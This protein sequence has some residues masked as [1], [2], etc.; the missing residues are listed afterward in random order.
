MA[1]TALSEALARI[2]QAESP[3]E[4]L[5]NAK[6]AAL[7]AAYHQ[8]WQEQNATLFPVEVEKTVELP[9]LNPATGRKSK[10]FRWAGKRDAI[11]RDAQNQLWLVE[12]KT[13]SDNIE[14]GSPYWKRLRIDSQISAYAL[15]CLQEGL[16]VAGV[17]YDVIRKPEIEP[18]KVKPEKDAVLGSFVYFDTIIEGE[19]RDAYLS[20]TRETPRMYRGRLYK[21]ATTRSEWYFGRQFVYRTRSE[22]LEYAKELWAFTQELTHARKLGTDQRRND[23]SCFLWRRPCEYLEYCCGYCGEDA[24]TKGEKHPELEGLANQEYLTTSRISTYATCPRKHHY[25]YE[26][27]L[28]P[29]V[30]DQALDFGTIFHEC[31]AKWWQLACKAEEGSVAASP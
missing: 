26:L 7:M 2:P 25:R 31:L 6:V 21:D 8:R 22:L 1:T 28:L 9:I 14:P 23:K 15:A 30:K 5:R 13:T 16:E 17:I 12:H 24:F 18:K 20:T 27:G 11:V 3:E 19:E 4:E 29:P 10:K